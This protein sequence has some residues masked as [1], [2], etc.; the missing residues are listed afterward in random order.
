MRSEEIYKADGL[1]E[2]SPVLG[3]LTRLQ[4]SVSVCR[5]VFISSIVSALLRSGHSQESKPLISFSG[6][7][8]LNI[9]ILRNVC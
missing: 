4:V 6:E 3:L 7:V 8:G 5:L 1:I 9:G 2:E